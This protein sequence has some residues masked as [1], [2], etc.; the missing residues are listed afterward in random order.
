MFKHYVGCAALEMNDDSFCNCPMFFV[1]ESKAL[2]VINEQHT[3]LPDQVRIL[4]EKFDEYELL[5]VPAEGWTLDE[6]EVQASS[7]VNKIHE[8]FY[9]RE[10]LSVVFVS[11]IPALMKRVFVS[12]D[13]VDAIDCVFVFHNDRREKKVLPGGKVVMVVA[14]EGWQL[15]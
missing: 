8:A 1:P 14:D 9:A 11:P 15:V 12:V 6:I 7:I 10:S 2:V 3:L 5:K 13:Y 4:D